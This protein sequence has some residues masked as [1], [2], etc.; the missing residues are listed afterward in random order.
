M[1]SK[2]KDLEEKAKRYELM[3]SLTKSTVCFLKGTDGMNEQDKTMFESYTKAGILL[4]KEAITNEY[5]DDEELKEVFN[6]AN[7]TMKNLF[8]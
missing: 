7:T 5:K 8:G 1:E 2:I 6:L 3:A 4:S